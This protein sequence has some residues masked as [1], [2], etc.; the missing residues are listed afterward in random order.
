ML[1]DRYAR[2]ALLGAGGM[3]EV[4]DG[5]DRLLAR[6]V[7]IKVLVYPYDRNPVFLAR[8]ER[9]AQ[10]AAGLGHPNIVNV[11]D[12]GEQDGTHFMVMEHVE[13]A[14]LRELLDNEGPQPVD[15]VVD[16]GMQTC[17]ALAAAHERGIVHRDVKPSNIMVTGDGKVKVT[18]FGLA[19]AA[20]WEH[21]TTDSAVIGTAKY[22]SPEHARRDAVD[23][24][25]DVYSLGICLYELLTG[26]A[27]FE[28]LIPVAIVY[29]HVNEEP[30]PPRSHDP[31][32]PA[33]LEAVVLRA[34]AKDPAARYQTADELREDLQRVR[35]GETPLAV[36]H[37]LSPPRPAGAADPFAPDRF[38]TDPFVGSH[39]PARPLTDEPF[40]DGPAAPRSDEAV[41]RA[42]WERGPEWRDDP[43]WAPADGES[44][45]LPDKISGTGAGAPGSAAAS[46]PRPAAAPKPGLSRSRSRSKGPTRRQVIVPAAA[47]G[48][49]LALAVVAMVAMLGW[50]GSGDGPAVTTRA[51]PDV[52]GWKAEDAVRTLRAG[53]FTDIRLPSRAAALSGNLVAGQTPSPG[54]RVTLDQPVTLTIP[55]PTPKVR[56]P[57][58]AG[59]GRAEA[60]AKLR[61]AALEVGPSIWRDDAGVPNGVV[62]GSRPGAGALVAPGQSVRLIVSLGTGGSAS[63]TGPGTTTPGSGSDQGSSP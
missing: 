34:M 48:A 58:V 13:G 36:L 41:F 62:T 55:G 54:S 30:K 5:W 52:R 35:D 50:P 19:V 4:F 51:M 61:S 16:L 24:R 49:L 32:I 8:F 3:G 56:V 39:G 18:D 31:S 22:I 28:G 47:G 6:R 53:G 46:G 29:C 23:A 60:S 26:H 42:G 15:R 25:S 27:P 7:A 12:I 14:N 45:L 63:G 44:W 57:P 20:A 21:I 33:E 17:S 9:E 59:L 10:A 11:F 2:G 38:P 43:G 1:H 40:P 37:P